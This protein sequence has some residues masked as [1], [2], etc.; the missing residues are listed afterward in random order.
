M[1]SIQNELLPST[2]YSSVIFDHVFSFLGIEVK[3][4]FKI[5]KTT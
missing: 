1:L 4:S 2:K 5:L 3:Y